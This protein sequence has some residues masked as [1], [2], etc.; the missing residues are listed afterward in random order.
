[1]PLCEVPPTDVDGTSVGT[2]VGSVVGTVVGVVIGVV[3]GGWVTWV[4]GWLIRVGLFSLPT[5]TRPVRTNPPSPPPPPLPP[6]PPPVT[7]GA[8]VP[9]R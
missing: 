2:C 1:M 3:I 7:G 6:A 8:W 5:C 4:G 9:G